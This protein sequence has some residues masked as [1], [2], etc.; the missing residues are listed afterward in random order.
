MFTFTC[1]P[2][3]INSSNICQFS[4]QK[5]KRFTKKRT[6]NRPGCLEKIPRFNLISWISKSLLNI[7]FYLFMYIIYI[8][9]LKQMY[10]YNELEFSLYSFLHKNNIHHVTGLPGIRH[11][12]WRKVFQSGYIENGGYFQ[13]KKIYIKWGAVL[14]GI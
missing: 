2:S 13:M 9:W 1:P 3:H 4:A 6:K 8:L 12:D 14:N 10:K 7:I 11:S 5:V